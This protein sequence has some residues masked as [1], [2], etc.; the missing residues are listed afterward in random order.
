MSE[1]GFCSL[2]LISLTQPNDIKLM[3]NAYYHKHRSSLNLGDVTCTIL[4]LSPF[5]NGKQL[6]EFLFPVLWP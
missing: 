3:H 1:I 6:P 2:T 5:T 4:E